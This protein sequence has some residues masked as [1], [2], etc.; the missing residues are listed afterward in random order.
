M[1][2][3][4][5]ILAAGKGTRMKSERAK[6]LQRLCGVSMIRLAAERGVRAGNGL[7]QR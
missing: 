7:P 3:H 4:V 5:V 2:L 1:E 6:V